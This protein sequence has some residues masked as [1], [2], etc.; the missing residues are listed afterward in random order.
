M[1]KKGI[2][3]A[4]PAEVIFLVRLNPVVTHDDY[5]FLICEQGD[6]DE[7]SFAIHIYDPKNKEAQINA[8]QKG[9]ASD[10]QILPPP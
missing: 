8:H 7:P 10:S 4:S 6:E 3:A 9:T 5:G 2:D 1:R